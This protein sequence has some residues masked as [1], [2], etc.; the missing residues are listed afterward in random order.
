MVGQYI[1][2]SELGGAAPLVSLLMT[3][4]SVLFVVFGLINLVVAYGLWK[5]ASWAWWIFLILLAL[6]IVSSLFMLPQGGV[7]IAQGIIGIIIN[8]III[9]YITRP[10][11]KEYFGV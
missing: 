10:H 6:G 7:G 1:P 8:G 11:V 3:V 4:G 5:G 9:Y 2:P